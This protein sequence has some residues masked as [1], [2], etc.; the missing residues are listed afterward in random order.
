MYPRSLLAQCL[1][2]N[3][4]HFAQGS[5]Y[6]VCSLPPPLPSFGK[7]KKEKKNKKRKKNKKKKK[8][9]NE[10][11]GRKGK[12]PGKEEGDITHLNLLLQCLESI[13]STLRRHDLC[14]FSLPPPVP[15]F[16]S[17]GKG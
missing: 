15:S 16:G 13:L 6:C 8:K 12:K 7:E 1:E 14:L 3:S 11:R 4:E 17:K 9:R 2:C 10:K 5:E